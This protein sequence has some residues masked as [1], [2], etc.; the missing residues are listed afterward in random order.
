MRF[1]ALFILHFVG[2]MH[3]LRSAG[4]KHHVNSNSTSTRGLFYHAEAMIYSPV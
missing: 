1:K 2:D 4:F 3:F